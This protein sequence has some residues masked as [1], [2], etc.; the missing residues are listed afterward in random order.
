MHAVWCRNANICFWL[1]VTLLD[2][3][4]QNGEKCRNPVNTAECRFCEFHVASAYRKLQPSRGGFLDSML[5]TAF[6]RAPARPQAQGAGELWSQHSA[7]AS[8]AC[9]PAA[10]AAQAAVFICRALSAFP[11]KHY[12]RMS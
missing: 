8:T 9:W 3:A 10:Q 7:S 6:S 4:A 2:H 5:S 12:A 1:A 11:T